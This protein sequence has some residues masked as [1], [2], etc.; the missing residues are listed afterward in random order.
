M[1]SVSHMVIDQ[2]LSMSGNGEVSTIIELRK[3]AVEDRRIAKNLD[4]LTP[5]SSQYLKNML[6][7]FC[8]N[9]EIGCKNL[10]LGFIHLEG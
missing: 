1:T 6:G 2:R 10:V 3:V 8:G 5:L 9:I 4:V 7:E